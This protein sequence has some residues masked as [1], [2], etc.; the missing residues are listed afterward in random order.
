MIRMDA[1]AFLKLQGDVSDAAFARKLGVS[2]SQL[3][4]IRTEK[5]AVGGDFIEKFMLCFPEE[6][7]NDYF[8][9]VS[10]AET[11]QEVTDGTKHRNFFAKGVPEAARMRTGETQEEM[12][13][14]G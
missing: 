10:D 12:T 5:C 8:Y 3:W 11:A 2:R 7:V 6:S 9:A 14:H 4:R 13:S 1:G